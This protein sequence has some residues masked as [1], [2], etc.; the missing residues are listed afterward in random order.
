MKKS[1]PRGEG[2]A[3]DK[4]WNYHQIDDVDLTNI[5]IHNNVFIEEI[6]SYKHMY[7]LPMAYKD[8]LTTY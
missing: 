5:C 4:F 1:G 7:S 3:K 8:P 6:A 2:R